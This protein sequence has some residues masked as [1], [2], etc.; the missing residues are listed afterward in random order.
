MRPAHFAVFAKRIYYP[1]GVTY[2]KDKFRSIKNSVG[3]MLIVQ[4]PRATTPFM[5]MASVISA[6]VHRLTGDEDIVI[7]IADGDRGHSDF[8]RLVGFTV[9]MLAIRSKINQEMSYTD[10]LEN[11]RNACLEAYK[12][13]SIP[14]DFLL[15]QL[16]VPRRTS[17][18]PVFQ[19]TVNYQ[20]Q[21]SFPEC[22]YGDFKFTR[23]DHY[24]ARTQ[25]DFG[26]DVEETEE[27]ELHC[28]FDFDTSLYS[29]AAVNDLAKI[30]TLLCRNV[31]ESEGDVTMKSINIVSAADEKFIASR[32]QPP[33]DVDQTLEELNCEL[34]P[35]LY[36]KAIDRFP[37]KLALLDES[38]SLTY[39][40][41][42]V[43]TDRIATR[44]IDDGAQVGDRI[45]VFCEQ[46][47]DM[48]VA[49]Y[50]VIAAGCAYVPIDPD[51][52]EERISSMI[53]DTELDK[54]L[55]D[56]PS[57]EKITR[58]VACGIRLS[59]LYH[60]NKI[61][62]SDIGL[63]NP[64]LSRELTPK[65]AFCCIFTSGS[66]GRPKGINIE[67]GSLRYQMKGF[68]EYLDVATE[69]R[70]LLS[71]A[72]VFDLSLPAIYGTILY[73]ATMVVAST[74]GLNPFNQVCGI[75]LTCQASPILSC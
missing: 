39:A 20:V 59:H 48:V 12:H 11:Y 44:L 64:K 15:Q 31:V 23:Y 13:R 26:L 57:D 56:D 3:A 66:T 55:I 9:N 43:A 41:I 35:A 32:L 63:R 1:N 70:I 36:R 73:S 54:V 25:S 33:F 68:N 42:G 21:G 45:G 2:S 28:V 17:H 51:F 49:M 60:I 4:Y 18:N 71:S 65:D 72:M 52:P 58:I 29:A 24:N 53:E 40:D 5:F 62:T 27:G 22:D 61:V 19:I 7:G 47:T 6:L 30:F 46:S 16:D 10:H 50:G 75:E 74:E 69:D 38:K 67:H 34:F 37:T 8:D 14:F